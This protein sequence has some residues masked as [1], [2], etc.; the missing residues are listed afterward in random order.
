MHELDCG[1]LGMVGVDF[2]KVIMVINMAFVFSGVDLIILQ[3]EW[4]H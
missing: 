4:D 1:G 2:V 3:W